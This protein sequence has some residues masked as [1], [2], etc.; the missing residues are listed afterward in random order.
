MKVII[1]SRE[2]QLD[3]PTAVHFG[4][5]P[6]FCLWDQESQQTTFIPNE[7]L[8]SPKNRGCLSMDI[9]QNQPADILV[10]GRFGAKAIRYC[11]DHQIQLIV[12]ERPHTVREIIQKF[13]GNS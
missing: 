7:A 6:W 13:D 9:L 5:A 8:Q 1:A 3:A 10:A 11:H 12:P 4:R 2:H